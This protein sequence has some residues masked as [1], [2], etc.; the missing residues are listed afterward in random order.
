MHMSNNAYKNVFY[1]SK[2]IFQQYFQYVLSYAITQLHVF[3]TFNTYPNKAHIFN[4]AIAFAN[5]LIILY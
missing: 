3:C 2:I 4:H 1:Y 5:A